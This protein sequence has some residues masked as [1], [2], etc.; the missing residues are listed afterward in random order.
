MLNTETIQVESILGKGGV[1]CRRCGRSLINPKSIER[2]YGPVCW[3]K[4]EFG[5][6]LGDVTVP[7]PTLP[8][9][10]RYK[11]PELVENLAVVHRTL[12]TYFFTQV[13]PHQAEALIKKA[14]LVE[15]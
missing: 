8:A 2:G 4:I 11:N 13:A 7:K 3:Q 15:G 6:W 12:D 5:Q 9:Q 1:C 14:I 10:R